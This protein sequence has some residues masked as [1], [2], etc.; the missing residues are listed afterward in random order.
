[1]FFPYNK[2]FS[3]QFQA[4][5]LV[6]A[7]CLS[8]A[9]ASYWLEGG[10][11]GGGGGHNLI[12]VPDLDHYE[13]LHYPNFELQE[14][15]TETHGEIPP[16]TV[17]VLKTISY[18]VPQPYP[19]HIPFKVPYPVH[20]EKPIPVVHTKIV[21]I[22]QPFPVPVEKH[23]PAE[24]LHPPLAASGG[25]GDWSGSSSGAEGAFGGSFSEPA[26]GVHQLQ[27]SYGVPGLEPGLPLGGGDYGGFGG[28]GGEDHGAEDR[29]GTYES[30]AQPQQ[31]SGDEHQIQQEEQQQH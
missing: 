18:K 11:G 25:G 24:E 27:E 12:G 31:Q 15:G 17:K 19:V 7:T 4:V 8:N 13:K 6:L 29:S 23:E 10:G 21:K 26:G 1:M 2:L 14:L 5:L 20:I 9:F 3:F 30:V 16:K 22:N 28:S